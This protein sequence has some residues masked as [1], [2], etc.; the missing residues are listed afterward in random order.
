MYFY[1]HFIVINSLT[2]CKHSNL[3][4]YFYNS[5]EFKGILANWCKHVKIESDEIALKRIKT[6]G[7][8]WKSKVTK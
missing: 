6:N 3:T 8:E 5:A 1:A 4:F 2:K 7:T